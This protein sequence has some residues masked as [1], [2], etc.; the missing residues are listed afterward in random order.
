MFRG[1]LCAVTLRHMHNTAAGF[2][3]PHKLS[4][5]RGQKCLSKGRNYH[6]P[7]L[8]PL[9]VFVLSVPSRVHAAKGNHC[10]FPLGQD[11]SDQQYHGRVSSSDKMLGEC[12]PHVLALLGVYMLVSGR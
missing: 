9:R 4:G 8:P 6:Q 10:A 7:I 1:T 3:L 11:R 5:M 12:C 2:C